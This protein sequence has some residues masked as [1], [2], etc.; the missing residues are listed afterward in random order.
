LRRR[1]E[2][3]FINS[4]KQRVNCAVAVVVTQA[5]Q[6]LFG[7]RETAGGGFEWQLPG[8]W[9]EV[10]ESPQQAARREVLEETGLELRELRFVGVTNNVFSSHNHSISLYFEAECANKDSLA[11]APAEKCRE[12]VW[13]QWSE[14]TN[15]LFLPLRL[16]RQ[17]G[18]QPFLTDNER[19]GVSTRIYI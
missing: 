2:G 1:A 12:W 5:R 3:G 7:R 16:L 13:R 15:D 17:T 11:V 9:I 14:V 10:G 8:G 18:Y 19:T 6:V 4:G